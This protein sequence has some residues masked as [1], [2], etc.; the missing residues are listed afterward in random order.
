MHSQSPPASFIKHTP[1]SLLLPSASAL[2]HDATT[3]QVGYMCDNGGLLDDPPGSGNYSRQGHMEGLF[4]CAYR[5]PLSAL[6]KHTTLTVST[7]VDSVCGYRKRSRGGG[8]WEKP[9]QH[10][11]RRYYLPID[12]QESGTICNQAYHIER[13]TNKRPFTGRLGA[14]TAICR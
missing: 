3:R 7:D 8:R 1:K 10:L 11:Q 6:Y 9:V 5:Q 12:I 13:G 4:F 14:I 2:R